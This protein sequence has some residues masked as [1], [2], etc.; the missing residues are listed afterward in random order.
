MLQSGKGQRPLPFPGLRVGP[1]VEIHPGL[2]GEL[3]G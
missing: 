3:T 2:M 1:K